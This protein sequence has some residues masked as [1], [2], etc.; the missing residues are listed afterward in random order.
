MDPKYDDTPKLTL[1]EKIDLPFARFA[2]VASALYAALTGVFRG[3][4]YPAKFSHHVIAATV[5]KVISRLSDQQNQCVTLSRRGVLSRLEILM[6]SRYLNRPTSDVYTA[7]ME[8]GGQA[9]ET[10]KLAHGAVGHWVGNKNAKNVLTYYH[11][12]S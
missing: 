9:P 12:E 11:G 6:R 2:V 4:S 5:R 8:G 1:W 3:K 10:V 7:F